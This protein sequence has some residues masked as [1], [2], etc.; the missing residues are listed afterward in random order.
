LNKQDGFALFHFSRSAENR[1]AVWKLGDI[2]PSSENGGRGSVTATFELSSPESPT[3]A[4]S[5]VGVAAVQF[6]AEGAT[7]S[8]LEFELVGSGYRLSLL[9]KR[10]ISGEYSCCANTTYKITVFLHFLLLTVRIYCKTAAV[11]VAQ[12]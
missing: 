8:G 3:A 12:S 9:K 10:V 2:S 4:K 1:R 6:T 5:S 7:L 11:A